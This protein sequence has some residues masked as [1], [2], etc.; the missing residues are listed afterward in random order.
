MMGIFDPALIES[1]VR[2]LIPILLAAFGGML[3]DKAGIFNIALEGQLLVGCFFAVAGSYASSSAMVGVFCGVLASSLFTLILAYGTIRRN[4]EPIVIGVAMNILASGITSFLLVGFF[5]VQGVFQDPKIVGL[6]IF[7]I[8]V[9][10]DIP[11]VGESFFEQ[12]WIGYLSFL[13][14]VVFWLLIFKTSWGLRLRGVGE[15]P[16]A[17]QTLGCN[18]SLYK[19]VAVLL[20]GLMTG[21]AGAQLA[22]G[23]VVQ[24]S[25]NMSGGR[26]WIAV[27]AVMLARS[28][29]VGIFAATILFGV[30]EAIG[31]R[32]QG[33]GLPAQLTDALPYIVTL[34]ALLFT[35]IDFKKKRR[36]K[37]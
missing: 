33:Q 17:A 8:P 23:N 28:H 13:L 32:L 19:Y 15:K 27:V 11:W 30:A 36:V 22:L 25:E 1:I 12:T 10:S 4:A 20:S 3:C 34:I 21:L 35:A 37:A 5:N 2:A 26:G 9:L 16:L 7:K 6:K 14:V 18:P 24:F 31:F 29:P